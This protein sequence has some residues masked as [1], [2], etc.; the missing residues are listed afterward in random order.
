MHSALYMYRLYIQGWRPRNARR[1]LGSR[2]QKGHVDPS[3]L[4]LNFWSV[5]V[6]VWKKIGLAVWH[7][8]RCTHKMPP[9]LSVWFTTYISQRANQPPSYAVGHIKWCIMHLEL[10]FPICGRRNTNT[11]LT[12][13]FHVHAIWLIT[14]CT[15]VV[16]Q[17]VW[18]NIWSCTQFNLTFPHCAL[19]GREGLITRSSSSKL[20]PLVFLL[21]L[22]YYL[23]KHL[24][25]SISDWFWGVSNF[26][27]LTM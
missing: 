2:N 17:A 8:G 20:L 15:R 23:R 25:L 11:V 12:L 5:E 27:W 6:L 7:C 1:V 19:H 16:I 14:K 9:W 13:A 18:G 21:P 26:F 10:A 24:S 4:S 22:V 3:D